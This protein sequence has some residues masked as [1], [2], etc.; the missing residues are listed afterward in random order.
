MVPLHPIVVHFPIALLPAALLLELVGHLGRRDEFRKV[1]LWLLAIGVAMALISV[2]TGK[3]GEEVAEQTMGSEAGE[4]LLHLHER[5]A[6]LTTIVWSIALL[7][8]IYLERPGTER[9]RS[10]FFAF[11]LLGIL[12]LFLTGFLGGRLVYEYGAGVGAHRLHPTR[13]GPSLPSEP[14]K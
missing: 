2:L 5:V 10:L 8:R 12:S 6:Y 4:E 13:F 9:W 11:A 7:L 14:L 1:A 3:L